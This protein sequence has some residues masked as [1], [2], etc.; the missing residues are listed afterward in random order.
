[1]TTRGAGPEPGPAPDR[2]VPGVGSTRLPGA[3]VDR[4]PGAGPD[5]LLHV[6]T[7]GAAGL[8]ARGAGLCVAVL[9]GA[10]GGHC[11]AG[12][13]LPGPTVLVALGAL[14]LVVGVLAARVTDDDGT[15]AHGGARLG[16]VVVLAVLALGLQPL[17]AVLASPAV[18]TGVEVVSGH[19]AHRSGEDGAAGSASA[20]AG[21]GSGAGDDVAGS[22]GAGA[23]DL[24]ALRGAGVDLE[25]VR[26]AGWDVDA[27]VAAGLDASALT[28]AGLDPADPHA[29]HHVAGAVAA[30]PAGTDPA[31][32]E[33]STTS[34]TRVLGAAPA[35]EVRDGVLVDLSRVGVVLLTAVLTCA[36]MWRRPR[37]PSRVRVGLRD[38]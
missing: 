3:N 14:V 4:V 8:L 12:G 20:G 34:S 9:V 35:G 2:G 33:A 36:V 30:L 6:R 19:A 22:A 18:A 7:T 5:R 25:T 31:T 16:A 27:L 26:A 21:S 32:P 10:V 1:M 15:G 38:G 37:D 11:L 13:H 28:A 24:A 29:V 23:V 17:L